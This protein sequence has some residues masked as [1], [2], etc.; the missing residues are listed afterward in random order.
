[1]T[2]KDE[3]WNWTTQCEEAC[4][5]LTDQLTKAPILSYFDPEK[6]LVVQVDSSKDGLGAVLLQE[7]KPIEFALKSLKPSERKW[8]QIEKEALAVLYDLERFDQYTYGRKVIIQNDHKPLETILKKPLSQAP[9]RLQ[10]IIMKLLRYDVEFQFMKGTDLVIADTLSRAYVEMGS[11]DETER[12]RICEVSVFEEFPDARIIEIREAS[13]NDSVLQSLIEVIVNGWPKKDEINPNLM[14]YFSFRDTLSHEHGI[15][16][17]GEAV[18]IPKSLRENIKMRLHSAHLGFDSMMRRA[19]GTIF[20]P[21]MAA[22]IKQMIEKCEQCQKLKPRNQRETLRQ[23]SDGNGPWDKVGTDLFEIKGRNFLLVIDYYSNFIE[24][25]Q[26]ST[27]TSKQVIEKLK[28]QFARLGI[29]RYIVSDG[30]PQYSSEEFKAFVREWGIIHHIT[31]P[32]HP[33]SNGKAEAGVKMIKNMMIK[34]LESGGDQNLALLE[35]RNTPRQDTGLSPSEMLFGRKTMTMLPTKRQLFKPNEKRRRRNDTVKRNYDKR[36]KD[37]PRVNTKKSVYFEH[38]KNQPWQQGRI[39]E[40]NDRNYVV[41]NNDGTQYKRN[42]THIRPTDVEVT[43]RDISPPRTSETPNM[44]VNSPSVTVNS[45]KPTQNINQPVPMERP[46]RSKREIKQP[47]YL[48]DYVR[49]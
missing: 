34:S 22:E 21:G 33:S 6:E 8:A 2:R 46:E 40:S 47:S 5:T 25:D 29:P 30:G 43:I 31:S 49:Y 13:K 28:K 19:R 4:K 36:A 45:E 3:E 39:V 17:K 42:R 41:Q 44:S 15:I 11:N 24:V 1:M 48:K 12:L 14:P 7:G 27:T 37:L 20:W 9:K 10:D 18:L 26:L 23:H 35:L 38:Q 32:N 16:L